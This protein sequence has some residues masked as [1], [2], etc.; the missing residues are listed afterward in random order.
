V[1]NAGDDTLSVFFSNGLGGSGTAFLPFSR[2]I[3]YNGPTAA[4]VGVSVGLG[5][6]HVPAIDTT[7]DGYPDLVGTDQ[8]TG[9]VSIL[10]NLGDRSFAPAVPY[11]AD[12]G[13]SEI[14]PGTTPEVI[15]LEATAGV[16]AGPLTPG[17]PIDLVTIDPGSNTMAVLAGL[18]GGRFANPTT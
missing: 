16:A 9:R 12:T 6:S 13:L 10:R 17:G 14:D 1:R 2:V 11:R 8:L 3:A 4:S 15:S 5:V 7:G 18:G